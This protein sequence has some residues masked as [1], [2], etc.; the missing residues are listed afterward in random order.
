[1]GNFEVELDAKA[2]PNTASNFLYYVNE[3]LY[4]D[5]IFMRTVTSDNQP[6]NTVKILVVQAVA[7]AARTNEY[8]PPIAL[9]RT[10]DTGL[11]HLEGAISMARAEPDTASDSFFVCVGD[12][13]E[14][15]FGGTRNPDGQGFAAF[16]KVVSGMEVIRKIHAAPQRDQRLT[17]PIR[18][19]RAVRLN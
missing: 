4:N 6:T 12:E 17:P 16:G 7:T 10:R 19:M 14:L 9:E 3:R 18:I 13:P 15:D 11:R 2:A 8:L 1:L 5:G